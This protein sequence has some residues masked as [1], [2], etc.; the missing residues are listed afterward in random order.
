MAG[1]VLSSALRVRRGVLS[2]ASWPGLLFQ[3]PL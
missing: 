2:R 3:F 1:P